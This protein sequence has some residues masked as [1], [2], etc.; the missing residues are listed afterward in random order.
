LHLLASTSVDLVLFGGDYISESTRYAPASAAALAEYAAGV[1][2][3][4]WAV[5]G[6]H[7]AAWGRGDRVAAALE[8]RGIPVLR[9]AAAAIETGRGT[10]WLAG[11]DD[12]ISGRPDPQAAF[13]GIPA[14]AAAIA[15]WH[16]PDYA[17][18]AAARGA[19]VQL[20]G[21]SHGGQVR[22]PGIGPLVLP[23]G[24][25]RFVMGWNDAGGMPIYTTRGVGVYRPP[26]RL[27]CPPEVTLIT[28]TTA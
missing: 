11:I 9:N 17:E 7:D 16:E 18:Q 27:N 4:G 12:V 26:L 1:R 3:G 23:R 15:L 14:G 13:A 21:H 10:L 22:L 28:L 6:N 20:S 25:Q 5:L 24:G 19:F 8:A 2:L